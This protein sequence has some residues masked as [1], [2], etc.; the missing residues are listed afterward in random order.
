MPHL[1][2]KDVPR[3]LKQVE[4]GRTAPVYLLAGDPFLTQEIHQQLIDRL[5]PEEM[6]SFNLE[7]LDGEKEDLPSI[8]EHLQTFPFLPGRKVVSV[9]NPIQ[10]LS[11]EKEERLWKKAEEAWQ[12]GQADRCGMLLLTLFRNAG[13]SPGDIQEGLDGDAGSLAVKVLPDKKGSLPSWLKE[14]LQHLPKEKPAF[15]PGDH[16]DQLLESALKKGFPKDHILILL[17][18]ALPGKKKI[19]KI[20]EEYGIVIDLSLKQSK[21]G[22]Q[23]AALKSYLRERLLKAGFTIQPQA[24]ALLLERVGAEVFLLEMELQKLIS[25]LGDRK[26]ILPKDIREVVGAGREEPLYEL[27]A[28]LGDRNPGQGL[29]VLRQLW[30]QGYNPLQILTGIINAFRRF[31]LAHELLP[32]TSDLP[33]QSWRDF[34][35]FSTRVMPRLKQAPLPE[36]LSKTHPYVLFNTLKAAHNFTREELLFALKALHETDR[37]LK[38]SGVTPAFLL[39]DFILSHCRGNPPAGSSSE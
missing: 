34:S 1:A 14:A 39:E 8:L 11:T 35:S 16:P 32:R 36:P 3:L 28:F 13:L 23:A 2:Y 29:R 10:I 38:T 31:L 5:I 7:A 21:K 4:K 12:K 18:E 19:L 17:A 24:E 30:E 15:S 9:R 22:E 6:R 33:Q 27:T 26:Q 20:L 25:Y 37:L